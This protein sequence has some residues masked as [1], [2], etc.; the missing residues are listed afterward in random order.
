MFLGQMGAGLKT[1]RGLGQ[2]KGA[3]GIGPLAGGDQQGDEGD[4]KLAWEQ[5]ADKAFA[6]HGNS[7]GGWS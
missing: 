4:D 6:K 2:L 7:R 3:E 1:G 5:L